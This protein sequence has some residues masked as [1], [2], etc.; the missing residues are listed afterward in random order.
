MF[1]LAHLSDPHLADWSLGNPLALLGKRVTGYLSWRLK[2]SRIHRAAVLDRLVADLRIAKP[3]HIAVTGDLTNISLP[4]EFAAAAS[5]LQQ[6]GVAEDVSVI[7][8][9]HDAYVKQPFDRSIGL[10]RQNMSGLLPGTV[11]DLGAKELP[12]TA[13]TDFPYVRQRGMVALVG[14]STAVPTLP[15]SAA[16]EIGAAQLA[17]LADILE[18]LGQA[19]LFR[20]LMI[21][22]PPYIA[23]GGRRKSLRDHVALR[24]VLQQK[25]VELILHGHTHMAGLGKVDTPGGYAPVI[26]V[27]SASAI[28][29]GHKDSSAYYLYRI[30]RTSE[31]WRLTVCTRAWDVESASFAAAGDMSLTISSQLA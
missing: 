3:D 1:T 12:I 20:V 13:M 26:G 28:K 22:H 31:N 18:R 30:E 2:R 9:N 5:W 21:H 14:A 7:P 23:Y 17:R 15:F 24:A 19:G 10:W 8:G 4:E 16:G 27:P 25:G 6:L 29:H 11:A